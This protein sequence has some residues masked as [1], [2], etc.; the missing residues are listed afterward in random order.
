M[1][2]SS[3]LFEHL[4]RGS[5]GARMT[6]RCW[7]CLEGKPSEEDAQRARTL[8][9]Y[10]IYNYQDFPFIILR[11]SHF[12]LLYSNPFFPGLDGP[13]VKPKDGPRQ[14]KR[15]QS[16]GPSFRSSDPTGLFGLEPASR[17][18]L[19]RNITPRRYLVTA[20]DAAI[21]GGLR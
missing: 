18:R 21:G 15:S 5:G 17:G 11:F 12:K 6:R 13:F 14:L 7:S 8:A 2:R 10:C 9:H 19:I 3:S 16:A 1:G 20:P 4:R